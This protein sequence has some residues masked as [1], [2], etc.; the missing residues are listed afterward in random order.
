MKTPNLRDKQVLVVGLARSGV[1]AAN[2]LYHLDAQVC[3]TDAQ[4]RATLAQFCRQ[5]QGNPRL[6][7]GR[8]DPRDFR[9]ADLIVISPGVPSDIPPIQLAREVG[10]PVWSEVEL[11]Y[12]FLS[13]PVIGVTGSNGKTTTTAL[14]GE[15]FQQAGV[16]YVVAGNIG[17]ALTATLEQSQLQP[18]TWVIELS[19][20]QLEN[21]ESFHCQVAV[22][23]NL[24]PDHQDRY[25]VFENYQRAKA[26]IF[27]NQTRKDYCV[28]NA[29][30]PLAVRLAGQSAARCAWFSRRSLPSDGAGITDGEIW[31]SWEGSRERL[32]AASELSL[33]GEHNLENALAAVA[34][35]RVSRLPCHPIVEALKSFSGV[36]HRLE[37]VRTCNGVEF[38]NDSKATNVESARVAVKALEGPLVVILGGLEKE[39]DFS[40]LGDDLRQKARALVLIGETAARLEETLGSQVQSDTVASME[41]A[42]LRAAE[43]A[44]QGDSVLLA[45]ACASFDMFLNFE[46][47]GRIFKHAVGELPGTEERG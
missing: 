15:M 37:W 36:E 39:Q 11:A 5:L 19:S 29:D 25:A 9:E 18:Q 17:N 31:W 24:S 42:V 35:A 34:A 47:R 20:F 46:E 22:L 6:V 14:L 40:S 23:L 21:I 45:P 41:E 12:Q 27:E 7:L 44:K 43:L 1:A 8:H 13:G 28:A 4:P 32:L 2:L 30:D 10:V 38:Y 26:R 3:V 16:R 33:K